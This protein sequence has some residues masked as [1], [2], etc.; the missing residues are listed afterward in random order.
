M[1][2]RIAAP[3]CRPL[4]RTTDDQDN[5][6]GRWLMDLS[7]LSNHWHQ[8]VGVSRGSEKEQQP[9]AERRFSPIFLPPKSG[10]PT[11]I[12][13]VTPKVFVSLILSYTSSL[14][15][16]RW[17]SFIDLVSSFFE[18]RLLSS[19]TMLGRTTT[20]STTLLGDR[21]LSLSSTSVIQ[22]REGRERE[23]SGHKIDHFGDTIMIAV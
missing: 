5:N 14:F 15:S 6:Y 2:L 20:K 11:L 13:L 22:C 1:F 3:P 4:G 21:L 16:S 8:W 23:P 10:D 17:N 7:Y 12:Q 19:C 9:G 18:S